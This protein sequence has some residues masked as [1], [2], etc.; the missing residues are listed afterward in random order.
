MIIMNNKVIETV[1]IC[2][3]IPCK[4]E[5]SSSFITTTVREQHTR[6]HHKSALSR[7]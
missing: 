1:K 4:V 3:N 6:S 2:D 5:D 7:E